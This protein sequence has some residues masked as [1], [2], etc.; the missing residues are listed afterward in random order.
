MLRSSVPAWEEIVAGIVFNKL[1]FTVTARLIVIRRIDRKELPHLTI[2]FKNDS[3][4]IDGHLKDE[5]APPGIDPYT[6]L[7]RL[8][9]EDLDQ[10]EKKLSSHFEGEFLHFFSRVK[11]IRPGW[12]KRKGYL[13]GLVDDE[14]IKSAMYDAAPK[15]R[16]KRRV[17]VERLKKLFTDVEPS[18]VTLQYP[19][20]LHS[21]EL[22]IVGSHM[23]AVRA[24]GKE[25]MIGLMYAPWKTGNRTW[26]TLNPFVKA[27]PRLFQES[28]S[29]E[30]K[31]IMKSVWNKV[32]SALQLH[33][34]GIDRD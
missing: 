28:L 32:H 12:L 16:G 26:V 23:L 4:E 8:S 5:L 10:F 2:S 34:L 19:S 24:W 13:I 29:P 6:P 22:R 3:G 18:K 7:F 1:L 25:R 33:E 17:D 15:F 30:L 9:N 20:V 31:L 14:G 27:M 21:G 11:R